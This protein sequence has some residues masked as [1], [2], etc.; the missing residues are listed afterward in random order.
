MFLQTLPDVY[1]P[2]ANPTP[3]G[4]HQNSSTYLMDL[5]TYPVHNQSSKP[6]VQLA[7]ST[8]SPNTPNN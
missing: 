2:F 8:H 1:F 3:H 6:E 4:T 5:N 7:I